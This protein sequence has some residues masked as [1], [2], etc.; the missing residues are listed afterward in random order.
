MGLTGGGPYVVRELYPEERLVAAA[1]AMEFNTGIPF[2]TWVP[3]QTVMVLEIGSPPVYS[4]P[5]LRI[6]GTAATSDRF[7][8]HYRIQVEGWQGET[9][10]VRLFLPEEERL[11]RVES[12]GASLSVEAHG[13]AHEVAVRFP[14]EPVETGVS[15]WEISTVPPT[16]AGRILTLPRIEASGNVWNFL[17]ARV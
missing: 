17:G 8:D 11:T 6:A 7:A 16:A 2:D 13:S 15:K 9:R 3:A 1:G 14:K 12:D 5:P 10:K 4:S